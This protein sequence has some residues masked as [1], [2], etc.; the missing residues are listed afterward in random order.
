MPFISSTC[1][2]RR[3]VGAAKC[4]T[5]VISHG[6]ARRRGQC[7]VVPRPSDKRRRSRLSSGASTS[8]GPP[9]KCT[10]G[11]SRIP[12]SWPRPG[13]PAVGWPSCHSSLCLPHPPGP[14]MAGGWHCRIPGPLT[15]AVSRAASVLRKSTC[16]TSLHGTRIFR[17]RR[18]WIGRPDRCIRLGPLLSRL[19][20]SRQA[21]RYI[22]PRLGRARTAV[23][24]QVTGLPAD[25][26][27]MNRPRASSAWAFFCRCTI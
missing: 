24:S 21:R 23:R 22:C 20:R 7:L 1:G 2:N 16:R 18:R 15:S 12:S 27:G 10:S 5:R 9:R 6:R 3:V 4:A 8:A 25:G 14:T 17:A 11:L 19:P 13:K 26:L